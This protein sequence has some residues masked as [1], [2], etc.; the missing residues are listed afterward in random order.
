MDSSCVVARKTRGRWF[1]AGA[2]VRDSCFAVERI[3]SE[4]PVTFGL[5]P[6]IAELETII[7]IIYTSNNNDNNSNNSSSSDNNKQ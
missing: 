3:C 5:L 4:T 2:A 6:A 1:R 7:L